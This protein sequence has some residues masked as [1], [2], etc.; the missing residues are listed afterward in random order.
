MEFTLQEQP[1]IYG[2][3]APEDDAPVSAEVSHMAH[4]AVKNFHEC[5]WWWN[6]EAPITTRDD[7]REVIRAL[8]LGGHRAWWAAQAL[9]KCL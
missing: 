2:A 8:R 4:E 3:S 1:A 9:Q 7:V 6:A 5:F